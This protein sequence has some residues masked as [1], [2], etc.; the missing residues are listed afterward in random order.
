MCP[1]CTIHMHEKDIIGWSGSETV[2]MHRQ[3]AE[4][5]L[6]IDAASDVDSVIPDENPAAAE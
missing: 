2:F 5:L 1:A 6:D 4:L 3:C